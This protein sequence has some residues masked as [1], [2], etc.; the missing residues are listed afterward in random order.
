MIFRGIAAHDQKAITVPEVHPVIGH[1][2]TPER[3]SQSRNSWAVSY[4]GLVVHVDH[5][6]GS[7]EVV[8]SPAFLIVDVGTS[9]VCYG[10]DPVD[11]LALGVFF[12]EIRV[13]CGLGSLSDLCNCPVPAFFLP[14]VAVRSPIQVLW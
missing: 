8:E 1:C 13:T 11:H 6:Q 5:T 2:A 3:L 7:N 10:L 14:L 4:S 12:Y 9:E